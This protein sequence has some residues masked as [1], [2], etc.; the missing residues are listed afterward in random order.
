MDMIALEKDSV[1]P[2]TPDNTHLMFY[3]KH[4]KH[5]KCM[6]SFGVHFEILP[7]KK[8]AYGCQCGNSFRIVLK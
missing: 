2:K 5:P 6:T 7:I 1:T 8:V 4:K 3:E